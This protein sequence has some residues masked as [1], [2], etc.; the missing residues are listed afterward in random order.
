MYNVY[1]DARNAVREAALSNDSLQAAIVPGLSFLPASVTSKK[2]FRLMCMS[3]RSEG[4]HWNVGRLQGCI[5]RKAV[6]TYGV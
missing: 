5:E 3:R 1:A 4:N 6:S 2:E